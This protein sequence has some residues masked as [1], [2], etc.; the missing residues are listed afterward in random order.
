VLLLWSESHITLV[1]G[2]C[3]LSFQTMQSCR[4]TQHSEMIW[5]MLV[6]ASIIFEP[7]YALECSKAMIFMCTLHIPLEFPLEFGNSFWKFG[8]LRIVK[9]QGIGITL[10]VKLWSWTL[11]SM[12]YEAECCKTNNTKFLSFCCKQPDDHL[13][14]CLLIC[15]ISLPL[16]CICLYCSRCGMEVNT[17]LDLFAYNT[18]AHLKSAFGA[19]YVFNQP[20]IIFSLAS[21]N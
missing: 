20:V 17:L 13:S 2:T 11:D 6:K 7:S 12:I 18:S 10:D 8:L 19:N 3:A 21:F 4:A 16:I 14:T 15:N 1:L 5:I 9:L